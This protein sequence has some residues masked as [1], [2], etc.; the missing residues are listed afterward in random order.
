VARAAE[1]RKELATTLGPGL[2]EDRLEVILDGVRRDAQPRADRARIEPAEKRGHDV[3][4]PTRERVRAAQEV[5]RL[6]RARGAERHGDL[7][8]GLALQRRG[9]DPDP[10]SVDRALERVCAGGIVL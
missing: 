9:L 10:A 3:S 6:G 1:A 8:V 7:G 4:F 5:E 2:P